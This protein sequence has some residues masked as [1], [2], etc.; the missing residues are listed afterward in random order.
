[1]RH[2]ATHELWIQE[3]VLRGHVELIKVKHVFNSADMFTTYLDRGA[4][5][6]AI[7]RINHKYMESRSLAAPA[8][9][10]IGGEDLENVP[11]GMISRMGST[12][13][14]SFVNKPTIRIS[15]AQNAL[16]AVAQN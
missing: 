5:E 1:M 3:H 10:T 12:G 16:C 2:I 9:N 15:L 14:R 13:G 6:E 8:L 7:S 4:L 11:L